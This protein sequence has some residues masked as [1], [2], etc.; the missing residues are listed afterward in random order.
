MQRFASVLGRL[1]AWATAITCV[2]SLSAQR[3]HVPPFGDGL[4]GDMPP[5]LSNWPHPAA[6]DGNPFPRS[7]ASEQELKLRDA[8]I[9]LGKTLFWDEQVSAD[10]TVACGTCHIP[11][12]G[13]TDNRPDAKF[14]EPG[15]PDDG[16]FTAFGVIRQSAN[17]A[18]DRIDYGFQVAPSTDIDRLVTSV[19]TPTMIGAYMFNKQFWD[20]RAGP[21]F[22]D[23]NGNVIPNFT[24][25]A[26]LEDQ[27]VGP[28]VS[29]IEMGH[30][31]IRWSFVEKKIAESYPLALV[32][33]ASVPPDILHLVTA[34]AL[35]DKI[36]D[37]TFWNHPQFGGPLGV[38]RER[39]ALAIAHY[40]RT[41]IPDHAPIDLGTMTP[42]MVAGFNLMKPPRASCFA[43]HSASGNPTLLTHGGRLADAFDNVLSDGKFH[44]I[45]L[46]PTSP[47]RK[48]TS[49][50]NVGLHQKF[51]S[52]GHGG[53][54]VTKIF[55]EN[56]D[57]LITFY[58]NQPGG[59]GFNGTLTLA[60]RAEVKA[61]LGG[62]LLD[63]RVKEEVFPFDR[64][65][66]AS[67]VVPFESNEYGNGTPG[68]S[69]AVGEIIA[70]VPLL[71]PKPGAA[72][73]FKMGVGHAPVNRP[74]FLL[75]SGS[76][77]GGPVIWVGSPFAVVAAQNTN[78]EGISTIHVPF[79][80]TSSTVGMPIYTQWM[81]DDA[82]FRA[83]SDAAVVVPFQF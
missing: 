21:T 42:S 8:I 47:A 57:E 28:P 65:K 31:L 54:G 52:T 20:M 62:A 7:T 63:P 29:P 49:L 59:L 75:F 60:E 45:S 67:E 70:N 41:L 12:S 77:G 48:T 11:A 38:T 69:G 56:F 50:R 40:E 16:N 34:G 4:I 36:F 74:A 39:F 71:V 66:L 2:A 78:A 44:Q 55:V 53:D 3:Q 27:A 64:P 10:N 22:K 79:P 37:D 73:W 26:S 61:F 83:F 33:P 13:G 9:Q 19:F 80:A 35:Y 82:G 32:D 14:S 46:T 58:D 15:H 30:E 5:D 6:P 17:P 72:N 76:P 68:P 43:C 24:D 81:F 51:F 1:A 25:W 18:T 23:V